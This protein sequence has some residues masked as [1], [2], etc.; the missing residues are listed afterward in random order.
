MPCNGIAAD[1][2]PVPAVRVVVARAGS[3]SRAHVR[4]RSRRELRHLLHR[5]CLLL[6]LPILVLQHE[7]L[8]LCRRSLCN[9]H[10][11]AGEG[12]RTVVRP[13]RGA[14][15]RVRRRLVWPLGP[16]PP[17][18][19]CCLLSCCA[20][21]R[22]LVAS[23]WAHGVE[24]SARGISVRRLWLA[25]VAVHFRSSVVGLLRCGLT[26]AAPPARPRGGSKSPF[27]RRK[28]TSVHPANSRKL[29]CSM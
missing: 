2:V 12:D 28:K 9:C 3:S 10:W 8:R 6:L 18:A 22:N 14:A 20:L 13:L 4:V 7:L 25:M 1:L 21:R 29:S 11:A 27:S 15:S 24:M 16:R 5:L 26:R 23:S 17:A 19:W